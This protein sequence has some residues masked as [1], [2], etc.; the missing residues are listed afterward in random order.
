MRTYLDA[1]AMAKAMREAL[2]DHSIDLPH[3]AALEVVARQFG[4]ANWNILS[5]KID[6]ATL[7]GKADQ[8]Q[9]A[10]PIIRIFDVAKAREFYQ[11]FLGFSVDWEHRFGDNFP[12]YQQVS[13]SGL[14]LHLSEHA[15]DASPGC[16]MIVHTA[17][18]RAFHEE[19]SARDYR[20]LKPG[21]SQEEWG[22]EMVV[23]DPFNNRIRFLERHSKIK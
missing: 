4:F 1:K 6:Q 13:R 20:Y 3:S 17:G 11:A 23:T 9:Q 7:A 8:F 19:L 15:G 2:S 21:I 10:I 5:A 14:K 22:L 18:L 16:N 12:L